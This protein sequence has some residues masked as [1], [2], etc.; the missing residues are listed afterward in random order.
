MSLT[1]KKTSQISSLE[2][3]RTSA[4]TRR[5]LV[6]VAAVTGAMAVGGVVLAKDTATRCDR[7]PSLR[8]IVTLAPGVAEEAH[9]TA[10]RSPQKTL[11]GRIFVIVTR[12][13]KTE[14]RLQGPG[15]SEDTPPF[16]GINVSRLSDK[17]SVM[18]RGGDARVF[19]YPLP[20]LNDLP[21]GE[22][23]VQAFMNVY[24]TFHRSDGS[25]VQLH[26]PCGDG[27]RVMW[28]TGNIYSDIQKVQITNSSKPVRLELSHVIPPLYPTPPGGTCQQANPPESQHVKFVKIKSELLSEFWGRPMYIAANILLPKGYEEHPE[29]RYPVIFVMAHH[30]RAYNIDGT[31]RN[32]LI[33]LT[34][35][36]FKEDGS[37]AFS[38]WWLADGTPRVIIV[39]PLSENPFYDT[40]YW[41]DSPNV[42]PYGEALIRELL[43]VIDK[44]FR[45]IG[46]TWARTLIGASSGGWMSLAQQ[47]FYPDLYGGAFVFCP[48][49]LDFRSFWL[50]NLYR[51]QNA[52]WNLTEWRKWPRPYIRNH[53]TGNTVVTTEQWAHLELAIGD[54]SRSGEYFHHLEATWGPQGPDGYPLPA[55]DPLTGEIDHAA[56]ERYRKYDI[57]AYLTDNWSTLEPKLR[58]RLFFWVGDDDNFFIDRGVKLLQQQLAS[59]SPPSDAKFHINPDMG[60]CWRL[61]RPFT[62]VQIVEL[63]AN[64]MAEHAPSD[65][66]ITS[67]RY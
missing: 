40:S 52:Y 53:L 62:P 24:E 32:P 42:G 27:H 12:N 33:T 2:L 65:A 37:N 28:S 38:Q 21:E 35:G 45:T 41:V 56:A 10:E 23:Y 49:N 47:V 66:D 31:P 54:E 8:F 48:D 30:P 46:E 5:I 19:G 7:E 15:L 39:R 6:V 34:F 16:W 3:N 9:E 57:N 67:W 36:S 60:H 51:D 29:A 20:A 64:H 18:L 11:D 58:G 1:P 61:W 43:P 22:Y 55:W 17:G 59:L 50:I 26:M 13:G 25:T 63:L 4:V 44:R 14:P